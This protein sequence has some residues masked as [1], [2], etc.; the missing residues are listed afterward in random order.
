MATLNEQIRK[1]EYEIAALKSK[2]KELS[3]NTQSK[4][5]TPYSKIGNS[6][7]YGWHFIKGKWVTYAIYAD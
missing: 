4:A 1:L 2:V 5:I 7:Y 3:K 6:K